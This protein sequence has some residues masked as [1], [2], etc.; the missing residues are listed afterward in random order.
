MPPIN[1]G[2]I[3]DGD[4]VAILELPLAGDAMDDR[5]VRAHTGNTR[6]G[7]QAPVTPVIE[8]V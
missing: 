5:L 4:D 7:R 1:N 6:I 3:I 2:A 8:E